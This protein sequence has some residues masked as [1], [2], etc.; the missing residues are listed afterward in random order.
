[1][2]N[3]LWYDAPLWFILVVMIVTF[4]CAS[5]GFFILT[6]CSRMIM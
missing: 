3:R 5:V 2:I 1:M 4:I 6:A